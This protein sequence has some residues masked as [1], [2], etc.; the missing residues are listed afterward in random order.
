MARIKHGTLVA[1]TVTAVDLNPGMGEIEVGILDDPDPIFF[2]VDGEDPEI[3]G[4][5]CEVVPSGI[6]A[7]L[8]VDAPGEYEVKLISV[9]TPRY[10]VRGL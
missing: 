2:R 9:G 4:D 1:D 10:W 6:G 7:A 5:D 8:R 3:D